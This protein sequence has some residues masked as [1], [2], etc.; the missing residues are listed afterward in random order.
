MSEFDD[1]YEMD[2]V[3]SSDFDDSFDDTDFDSSDADNDEGWSDQEPDFDGDGWSDEGADEGADEVSDE[4][5]QEP[6]FE[7]GYEIDESELS[8]AE[9][10]ELADKE[11]EDSIREAEEWADEQGMETWSDGTPRQDA[12]LSDESQEALAKE[13]EERELK[14]REEQEQMEIKEKEAQEQEAKEEIERAEQNERE[15]N[16]LSARQADLIKQYEQLQAER[17]MIAEGTE[18]ANDIDTAYRFAEDQRRVGEKMEA[19]KYEASEIQSQIDAK[20]K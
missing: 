6:D 15:I 3:D 16:E 9:L 14:E 8:P 1:S 19:L 20:R 4:T 7:E 5:D 12:E 18:N 11:T 13:A 2:D 17:D 10:K